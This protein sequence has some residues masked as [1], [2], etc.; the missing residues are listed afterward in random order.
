[1][2][3]NNLPL[4]SVE[5]VQFGAGRMTVLVRM[6]PQAAETTPQQ[7]QQLLERYPDLPHHTC[8]NDEGP[9]FAAVMD[10]TSTAHLLEH[11][12]ISQQ[13]RLSP[14]HPTQPASHAQ[15]AQS[16]PTPAPAQ[17]TQSASHA[18]PAPAASPASTGPFARPAPSVPPSRPLC[19]HG[20]TTWVSRAEGRARIEVEFADDLIALE[21][22]HNALVDLGRLA[23]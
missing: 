22:L 23:S 13:L 15:P 2:K 1:M 20:A 6:A 21:A 3:T 18:Q 19:L 7:V 8:V 11:L 14:T 10:H 12:I 4:L 17:P 16:S 5:K 9:T